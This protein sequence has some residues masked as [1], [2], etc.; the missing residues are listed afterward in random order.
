MFNDKVEQE[1]LDYNNMINRLFNEL[2]LI[3]QEYKEKQT[4]GE[5]IDIKVQNEIY[6]IML[7]LKQDII[8][9]A[10]KI[11]GLKH[12]NYIKGKLL[13]LTNNKQTPLDNIKEFFD[14]ADPQYYMQEWQEIYHAY[15]SYW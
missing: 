7:K 10:F 15:Y 6:D 14:I 2:I 5:I 9:N 13:S 1:Y 11:G 4:N 3:Y 12:S 8:D